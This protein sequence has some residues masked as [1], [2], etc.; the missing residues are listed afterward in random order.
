MSWG[1]LLGALIPESPARTAGEQ[2]AMSIA[3]HQLLDQLP[4]TDP[5]PDPAPSD[6]ED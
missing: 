2:L 4:E 3:T 1:R 5:D 6:R